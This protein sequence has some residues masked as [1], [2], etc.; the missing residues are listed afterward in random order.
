M[1]KI[2]TVTYNFLPFGGLCGHICGSFFVG[3]WY[4]TY[5]LWQVLDNEKT[6]A[7]P[8]VYQ[9]HCLVTCDTLYSATPLIRIKIWIKK[10]WPYYWVRVKF[11]DL[12]A[13]ITNNNTIINTTYIAFALLEQ[14]VNIKATWNFPSGHRTLKTGY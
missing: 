10:I 13:V 2:E 12:R 8:N 5:W 14:L 1:K 9:D 11:H 7:L 4:R 3:L 6:V